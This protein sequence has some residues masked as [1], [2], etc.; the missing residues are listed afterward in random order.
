ML[1]RR[2]IALALPLAAGALLVT[3]CGSSSSSG[4]S[5]KPTYTIGYQG[6]LTGD[7]SALGINEANAVQLAINQANQSGNLPFTLAYKS[8]DDQ[9][10][11]AQAPAAAQQLLGI[12]N[13][14]AVVGP[15]FSGATKAVGA[16]YAG[17][18]VTLVSPSATNPTLTSLGFTSFFRV[19]PPDQDQ[20]SLAADYLVKALKAKTVYSVDDKS[21]YGTGLSQVLDA[22]LQKDGATVTHQG[23][24]PTKNYQSI[25]G[26]IAQA[27]PDA[28]YYSGYYSDYALFLK[29]LNSAGYQ[30]I[31][32]SGDGS[33][34]DKLIQ[35]AGQAATNT[36]LTCPCAD[37]NVDPSQATFVSAYTALAHQPPGTYS[38]EAYD[39]TNAL[40]SAMKGIGATI[41]PATLLAA[42]RTVNY[43]GI[44]KD[45]KFSANGEVVGEA[46]YV[47]QVQNGKRKL[48]GQIPTLLASAG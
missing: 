21:D 33:N 44:T 36:Y 45:I 43:T 9:G 48:L 12:S 20:G 40:I 13:L 18:S 28:V 16:T 14:V 15:A 25:A 7:N 23:I 3:A 4:S 10:D 42:F 32:A 27:K 39:A 5:S 26:T 34:D 24:A 46:V 35:L 1:N 47:Y 11:P 2:L 38:A 29:A 30:G 22:Q 6:P 19:V 31:T 37:P 41:T 8:A 17:K